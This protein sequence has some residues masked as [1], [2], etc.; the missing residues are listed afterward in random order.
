[1]SNLETAPDIAVRGGTSEVAANPVR[2]IFA[3]KEVTLGGD[4]VVR[5]LLPNLGRRMVGPWCFIDHYGP[6]DISARAGMAVP[7]HPHIGLQT[8]S[9]LLDGEVHH[10]DSIGSDQLIRPGEL[11]LMTAG[12][13]IAHAE[14]SPVAHPALLHGVQL[15]V[16]LPE[17]SRAT[18]PAW[19]HHSRLPRLDI[20]G[21]SATVILGDVEGERSPG[22]T[23][24]PIVGLD[25]T[26][27][28]GGGGRLP[29]E[30]EFEYAALVMSGGMEADGVALAPGSM[31]YL[32]C[33]RNDLRL[34]SDAGARVLVLGGQPFEERIVMWWNFVARSGDEIAAAREDWMAGDRFGE[35]SDA[36]ART[37]APAL[38]S[39]TLKPRGRVRDQ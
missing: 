6:D 24:A 18:A 37:P 33:G 30:A 31:L 34:A 27:P 5:R 38:P 7:P 4:T 29:L 26:L 35:V 10:R 17:A 15:W 2:E 23:F 36:G 25:V 11:G 3:G 16:A 19:Q 28:P 20:A 1:M 21:L 32:G 9:W 8:V 12:A 13:G 22:K 39:G 14:H